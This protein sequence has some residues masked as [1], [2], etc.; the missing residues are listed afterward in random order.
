MKAVVLIVPVSGHINACSYFCEVLKANG[1]DLKY[2]VL[3][4]GEYHTTDSLQKTKR[5]VKGRGASDGAG[6]SSQ[7]RRHM[8]FEK[9][10]SWLSNERLIAFKKELHSLTK[11]L[12][13]Y[14][15]DLLFLDTFFAHLFFSLPEYQHKI[16]LLNTQLNNYKDVLVPPIDTPIHPGTPNFRIKHFFLWSS[17]NVNKFFF[18]LSTFWQDTWSLTKKLCRKNNLSTS[19]AIWFNKCFQPGISETPE[20]ILGYRSLDF[21]RHSPGPRQHYLA[22]QCNPRNDLSPDGEKILERIK[23]LKVN[24]EKRLVYCSLGTL[25]NF[26]N[27]KGSLRLIQLLISVFQKRPD[28]R[29]VISLQQIPGNSL[30]R[31]SENIFIFEHVPQ[32][33]VLPFFDLMITH[34]GIN[35]VYECIFSEVPMLAFPLN[36]SCDQPGNAA[37]IAYHQLGK[38]GF[39]NHITAEQLEQYITTILEDKT[40]K[41][42]VRNMKANFLKEKNQNLL[43]RLV[44][45]LVNQSY[46]KPTP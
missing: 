9:F 36:F 21:P 15:P 2:L 5:L 8:W 3:L 18:P 7:I 45:E 10:Y 17:V 44:S 41:E 46:L 29:L 40:Y 1:I 20:L 6:D 22:V 37:R 24:A 12:N 4:E 13:E 39:I 25:T 27:K 35:S 14:K 11:V 26:H 34:A 16:L 23:E 19:S 30:T 28:W 38:F 32:I 42:N 43:E 33:H 31:A